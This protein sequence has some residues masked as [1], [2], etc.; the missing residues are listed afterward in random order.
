MINKKVQIKFLIIYCLV[1]IFLISSCDNEYDYQLS[2]ESKAYL[3]E[4][5]EI[6][7]ANSVNKH[8]IDWAKFKNEVFK[9]AQNSQTI[10]DTYPAVGYAITK[11]EDNHSYFVP[12]IQETDN[13]E[14]KKLP[15]V[16]DEIV[17]YDI[18]YIRIP[19][20]IGNEKMTETY[21]ESVAGKISQQN[22]KNIKGWIVDLR[23]NFGGNMWPM[24]V[25]AGSLL[26]PG[27][28]GYFF[29]ADDNPHEWRYDSG[30]VYFDTIFIAENKNIVPVYGTGKIAVLINRNTASSGEAISVIFKG[31][32]NATLFGELTFGV[33]TGCE[34]F[35]LS[36]SSRINLATSVF[37]DR[38][39]IKYG[40]PILPDI[41]CED[42]EILTK[43]IEWIYN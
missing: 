28:Q 10:K 18:G 14:E 23:D 8:K 35:S 17:P 13:Q 3:E 31:Y 19:F 20:C 42:D 26:Q 4:V 43:A 41:I 25:S 2:S 5:L 22:S 24:M 32:D 40:G 11:L 21:V 15:V 27:I 1:I 34:S 33:S 30:K 9:Y 16:A 7:H 12:A 29:D 38:K 39:K 6:L 36:D 37:A